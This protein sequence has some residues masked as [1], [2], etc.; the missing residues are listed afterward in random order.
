LGFWERVPETLHC[1]AVMGAVELPTVSFTMV[2]LVPLKRA[3]PATAA[4]I[5]RK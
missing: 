2:D 4:I 3:T 1:V 5:T